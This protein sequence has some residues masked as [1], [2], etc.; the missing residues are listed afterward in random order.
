LAPIIDVGGEL[1]GIRIVGLFQVIEI[2]Q[3]FLQVPQKSVQLAVG[4]DVVTHYLSAIVDACCGAVVGVA[5]TVIS[6]YQTLD[7][8]LP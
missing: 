5:R 3:A 1:H 4:S 2:P 7:P 8:R 6:R